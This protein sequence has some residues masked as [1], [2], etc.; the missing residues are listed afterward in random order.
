MKSLCPRT[1]IFGGNRALRLARHLTTKAAIAGLIALIPFGAQTAQAATLVTTDQ[2]NASFFTFSDLSRR[3]TGRSVTTS[4]TVTNRDAPVPLSLRKFD[5]SLGVL[6]GI[7][8]SGS[9]FASNSS[10]TVSVICRDSGLI[11]SDC[12]DESAS[13]SSTRSARVDLPFDGA[14]YL[15]GNFSGSVDP[16]DFSTFIGTGSISV[17]WQYSFF[18]RATANCTPSNLTNIERCEVSASRRFDFSAN[19]T[20]RYTYSTRP[21]SPVPLPASGLL[22]LGGL[23]ALGLRR[24]R[25]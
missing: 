12:R 18:H 17:P 10:G 15:S 13:Q 24:R 22:L 6:E 23:A 5:P 19:V 11:N 8:F 3:N 21:P 16:S 9:V 2:D 7:S 14:G 4:R 1:A 25:R 20:V